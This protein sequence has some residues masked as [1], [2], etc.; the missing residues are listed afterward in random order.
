MST[1]KVFLE[2]I[3]DKK[4]SPP[5]EWNTMSNTPTLTLEELPEI[6]HRRHGGSSLT[7]AVGI[8]VALGAMLIGLYV[9]SIV[10]SQIA[11]MKPNTAITLPVSSDPAETSNPLYSIFP[12]AIIGV[13]LFVVIA[14]ALALLRD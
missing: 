12:L 4:E 9:V 11:V 2:E 14:A 10:A 1:K 3:P 5:P 13:G 7:S 8:V 6:H